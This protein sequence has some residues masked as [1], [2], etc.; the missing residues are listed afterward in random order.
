MFDYL[1]VLVPL[2]KKSHANLRLSG[3]LQQAHGTCESVYGDEIPCLTCRYLPGVR[4][5]EASSIS[6][7]VDI[8]LKSSAMKSGTSKE[9]IS[10]HSGCTIVPRNKKIKF[11]SAQ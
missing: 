3:R 9:A 2:V 1:Q 5:V 4:L 8:Y 11:S 7:L 6:K 10:L